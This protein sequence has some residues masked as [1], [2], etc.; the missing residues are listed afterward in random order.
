MFRIIFLCDYVQTFICCAPLQNWFYLKTSVPEGMV[1]EGVCAVVCLHH[2]LPRP[3]PSIV[4]KD[5]LKSINHYHYGG[6]G[7]NGQIIYPVQGGCHNTCS[8][9]TLNFR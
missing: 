5:E 3:L 1:A 2:V 4:P 6:R 9:L 8:Q 7:G